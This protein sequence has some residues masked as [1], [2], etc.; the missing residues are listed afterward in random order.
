MK[1]LSKEDKEFLIDMV[2][3][4]A[5]QYYKGNKNFS[6]AQCVLLACRE[7]GYSITP[8]TLSCLTYH[9]KN[10]KEL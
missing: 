2:K 6:V 8:S 1:T 4:G 3:L 5:K 9:I 7:L 10:G